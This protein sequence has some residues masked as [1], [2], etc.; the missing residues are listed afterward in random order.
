MSGG[1]DGGSGMGKGWQRWSGI[2]CVSRTKRDR[3]VSH[4]KNAFSVLMSP[5]LGSID[6]VFCGFI[7]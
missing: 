4:V 3:E 7:I 1:G 6:G 2:G 5:Q